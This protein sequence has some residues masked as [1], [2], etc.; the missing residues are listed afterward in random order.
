[1]ILDEEPLATLRRQEH[2]EDDEGETDNVR[3][4]KEGTQEQGA[5]HRGGNGLHRTQQAGAHRANVLHALQD[6]AYA[7][8][9]PTKISTSN[10]PQPTPS[11]AGTL[12]HG[13][14][15]IELT[16]P[17]INIAVPVTIDEP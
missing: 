15:K 17:E 8:Q 12:F 16:I 10:A 5:G 7:K 13:W 1:M 3:G 14:I 2:H 4:S 11:K 9:D 6:S